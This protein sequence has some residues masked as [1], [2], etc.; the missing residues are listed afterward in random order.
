MDLET[1]S[2][3]H[4]DTILAP[5]TQ[6]RHSESDSGLSVDT[7]PPKPLPC[8]QLTYL[9]VAYSLLQ[10]FFSTTVSGVGLVMA[11]LLLDLV[12][13]WE[14]FLRVDELFI[15]VPPLLG[16]KGN[17][18]MT[19]TARLSTAANL[20]EVSSLGGYVKCVAYNLAL[21]QGQA[22][23][24]S[25]LASCLAVLLGLVVSL[26]QIDWTLVPLIFTS[27]LLAACVSGLILGVTMAVVVYLCAT[28]RLNPDNL[29]TPMAAAM[30]DLVTLGEWHIYLLSEL[31]LT[32]L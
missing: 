11:G 12:Q 14:V 19:L 17:L 1:S 20:G 32:C 21:I 5:P 31:K 4:S 16:L 3:E 6:S 10:I 2:D 9:E 29:A 23:M 7:P 18:E 28:L 30:G 15:L 25:L 8:H 13:H 22:T 24:V 27:A 26:G